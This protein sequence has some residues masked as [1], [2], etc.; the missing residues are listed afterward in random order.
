MSVGP[1]Q[2]ANDLLWVVNSPSLIEGKLV[3]PID[4]VTADQVDTEALDAFLHREGDQ[5]RVGLYFE[6][7]VH[8]WLEQICGYEMVA[9]RLPVFEGKRTIGELDFLYLDPQQ[10]LTH[11]EVAVKF[12]LHHPRAGQSH[13]PGPNDSDNF[14][15]KMDR[16][17]DHQLKL[18]SVVRPDIDTHSAVVKGIVFWRDGARPTGE[19][20]SRLAATCGTGS[21]YRVSEFEALA[22]S[23]TGTG[24]IAHKPHWL[25]PCHCADAIPLSRLRGDVLAQLDARPTP[26]MLSLRDDAGAETQRCFV[27]PDTWPAS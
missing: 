21:W 3:A 19:L 5:Y 4:P 25:A 9:S 13:F 6:S 20:P 22:A 12:Y 8:F 24:V 17:F 16:L 1:T 11:C 2:A 10:G 23:D 26:V 7:L 15:R 14:E 18:G 27:V